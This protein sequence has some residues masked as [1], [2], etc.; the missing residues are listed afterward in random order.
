[1]CAQLERKRVSKGYSSTRRKKNR[2]GNW[3]SGG[4]KKQGYQG[5]KN[6]P[7]GFI[8]R[9]RAPP[10]R[11]GKL[12]ERGNRWW[13]WGGRSGPGAFEGRVGVAVDGGWGG[14]RRARGSC[15]KKIGGGVRLQVRDVGLRDGNRENRDSGGGGGSRWSGIERAVSGGEESRFGVSGEKGLG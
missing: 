3:G 15:V 14:R 2:G 10:A 12:K 8:E 4:K 5:D 6:P 9:R 13:Y 1:M 7:P 11:S